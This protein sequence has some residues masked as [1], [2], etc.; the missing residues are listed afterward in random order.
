[1]SWHK[2]R[3]FIDILM[4]IMLVFEMFYLFTGNF[5]HE[6]VGT[7][8]FITLIAH[9]V[10]SRKWLNGVAVKVRQRQKLPFKNKAKIGII[11]ALVASLL[12]LLISSVLISNILSTATGWMLTG[13]LY[14]V[15]VSVHTACGYAVCIAVICHVGIHWVGLFRSLKIPY[16]P[17]RRR[18]INVGVTTL[19]SIGVIAVAMSAAKE[20]A[21]LDAVAAE[22]KSQAGSTSESQEGSA[23]KSQDGKESQGSSTSQNQSGSNSAICTLCK[24]RCSLSAPKCNK[25]YA[26]GLI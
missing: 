22:A 17:G 23:S 11:I 8:F 1:M 18:A 2:M 19:T 4:G 14:D 10:L 13:T 9:I 24:K 3:P 5:L 21:L 26:A 25:P 12:L 6:V 20:L 7:V 15:L 16:D